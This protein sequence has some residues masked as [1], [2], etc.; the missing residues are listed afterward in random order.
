MRALLLLITSQAKEVA[1]LA[2]AI[3]RGGLYAIIALLVLT[4]GALFYL[5]MKSHGS[6]QEKLLELVTAQTSVLTKQSILTERVE[7]LLML[8]HNARNRKDGD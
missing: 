2:G 8:I 4:V 1:D 5:L 7:S 6:F 3:E